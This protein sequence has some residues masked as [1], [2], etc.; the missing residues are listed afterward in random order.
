[1]S[2]FDF[3]EDVVGGLNDVLK[4][5]WLCST[6]LIIHIGDAP[7]HGKQYHNLQADDYPNGDPSGVSPES[8]MK[9]IAQKRIHYF[10]V[11]IG[12]YTEKMV[13]IFKRVYL[14]LQ[15]EYSF[16]VVKLGD[17]TAKFMPTVVES[18]KESIRATQHHAF[19]HPI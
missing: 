4:L 2:G 15:S 1:M 14:D 6:R 11:E 12:K 19:A 5:K 8:L 10:F 13:E 16:E 18:I 7:C 3:P 9:K 17:N